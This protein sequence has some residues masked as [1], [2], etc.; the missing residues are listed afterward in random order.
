MYCTSNYGKLSENIYNW[1]VN[2][3][4]TIDNLIT[5]KNRSLNYFVKRFL[6]DKKHLEYW[7]KQK[8]I[9]NAEPGKQAF[10]NWCVVV[11]NGENS[12]YAKGM[13]ECINQFNATENAILKYANEFLTEKEI[14]NITRKINNRKEKMVA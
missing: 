6:S 13:K 2:K 10:F 12:I 9:K 5:G 11:E 8:P 3:T 1:L 14:K 7:Q 4:E